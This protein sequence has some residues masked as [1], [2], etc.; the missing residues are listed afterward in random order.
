M[1]DPLLNRILLALVSVPGVAA[2]ALGGSR[3]RGTAN[4]TSD[5]DIGLYYSTARPIDTD[6]LQKSVRRLNKRNAAEVTPIGGWG[7]WIVGGGWLTVDGH[8]VDLLYRNLD[9][10]EHVIDAC[11]AGEITMH[12]QPGHPHGFCSSIWMGEV[13]L[14]RPLHDAAGVLAALKAKTTPY[15][16]P[17]RESLIKRFQWEVL[18]AIENAEIAVAHG[19]Q[20]HIAGCAYRTLACLAQVLFALNGR[21]LINEKGALQEAAAFARTLPDLNER[22]ARIWHAIGDEK[23]DAAL[24]ILRGLEGELQ[25]LA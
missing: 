14:C 17:L 1:A 18:F 11:R 3:A 21:Y 5:Y 2:I 19:E 9:D 10:V 8:K 20:T 6:V 23:F 25:A 24:S 16:A 7:P 22:A 15:P 4:E 13:A 12:Y